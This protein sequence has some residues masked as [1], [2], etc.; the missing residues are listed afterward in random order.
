MK[1]ARAA[2]VEIRRSKRSFEKKLA[3]NIDLD[4]KSFYAYVRSR[5]R[6]RHVVGPLVDDQGDT[7]NSPQDL[8]EKFNTYFSSVFTVENLSNLPTADKIFHGA[9]SDK[10]Q[11]VLFD[12]T[13]VRKKLEKL[14]SDKASGVDE[15]SPRILA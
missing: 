2:A 1:A 15:L 4:R 13:T 5:S 14:R 10:L 11:E 12:E 6:S 8:A 3:M 7:T 9:E